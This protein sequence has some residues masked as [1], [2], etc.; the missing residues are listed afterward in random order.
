MAKPKKSRSGRQRAETEDAYS[1]EGNIAR[2]AGSG[3]LAKAGQEA[4]ARQKKLGI[5]VTF[6]RGDEVI[7]Q[8]PD[9]REEVLERIERVKYK[10]PAGVGIIGRK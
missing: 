7:K 8:W 6:K 2:L 4:I 9:G 10:L 1:L 3:E 5:A